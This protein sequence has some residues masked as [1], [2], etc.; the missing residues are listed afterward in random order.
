MFEAEY[1][2]QA[3]GNFGK[4]GLSKTHLPHPPVKIDDTTISHAVLAERPDDQRS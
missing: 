3:A 4:K 1:A 2:E